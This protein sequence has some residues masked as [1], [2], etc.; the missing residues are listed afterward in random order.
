MAETP[1]IV[2]WQDVSFLFLHGIFNIAAKAPIAFQKIFLPK[3]KIVAGTFKIPQFCRMLDAVGQHFSDALFVDNHLQEAGNS[4][5]IPF[6]SAAQ[7]IRVGLIQGR[8]I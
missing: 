1:Q 3:M 2:Q 4:V 8:Y 5:H 7:P 6:L